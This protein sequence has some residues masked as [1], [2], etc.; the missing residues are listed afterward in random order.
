ML[1]IVDSKTMVTNLAI[2][3]ER[4]ADPRLP[5]CSRKAGYLIETCCTILDLD[6]IGLKNATSIKDY[7]QLVA[8]M[9]QN[10]YPERLGDFW[11]VNPPKSGVVSWLFR[12]LFNVAMSWIDPITAKK[13]HLVDNKQEEERFKKCI[14][15]ANLPK[16]LGGECE[17]EGGCRFSDM[18]PWRDHEWT[19]PPKWEK[20]EGDAA[21]EAAPATEAAPAEPASTEGITLEGLK[22]TD[23]AD[24]GKDKAAA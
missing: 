11:L 13:I 7:L 4:V 5:A 18:G 9:S 16:E 24:N 22:L 1:E 12:P 21:K 10:C 14:D 2:E 19:R 17:C 3:Y 20:K 23:D 6:N 15:P 8:E